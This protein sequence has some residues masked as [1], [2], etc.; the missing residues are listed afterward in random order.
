MPHL[1]R[2]AIIHDHSFFHVTWKCHNHDWLLKPNWAKRIY[3]DLLLKYKDQYEITFYA[4]CFMS[5]HPH[6]LG[7]CSQKNKFSDFFR[8]VNS[9]FAKAYNKQMKRNGQV[10]MDRFKSPQIESNDYLL[11]VMHYID[12]NPCRANIVKN[13][14]LYQWSSYG[15]YAWGKDD[16]LLTPAPC[17][18]S[19]GDSDEQRCS[20]YRKLIRTILDVEGLKKKNYSVTHFIGNPIWVLNKS[21]E[22]K[23]EIARRKKNLTLAFPPESSQPP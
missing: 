2:Y 6:L 14:A 11:N 12:L 18:L 9:Q 17:Y 8:I 20:E 3:Y 19:L 13:P 16:P 23:L 5:N 10:V 4:Y 15:Y 1:P 21:N 22:L 7:F